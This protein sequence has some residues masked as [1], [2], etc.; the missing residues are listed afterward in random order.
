M[1]GAVKTEFQ[2]FG[3]AL[4]RTRRKLEEATSTIDAAQT[5]SNVMHR[6]LRAVEALPEAHAAQMLLGLQP[7]ADGH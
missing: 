6:R 3:D 7:D 5:R 1:L 4:A 2:R